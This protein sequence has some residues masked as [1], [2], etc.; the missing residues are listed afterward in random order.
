MKHQ[1][2]KPVIDIANAKSKKAPKNLLDAFEKIVEL[3]RD[4]ELSTDFYK[5]ARPEIKFI[6]KKLSLTL[7]EAHDVLGVRN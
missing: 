2:N 6:S 5:A 4:S 1:N 3:S 7:A